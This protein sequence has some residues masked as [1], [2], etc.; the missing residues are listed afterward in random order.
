ML[1]T[2]TSS[3][4]LALFAFCAS[5]L[6]QVNVSY[7][8]RHDFSIALPPGLEAPISQ[9]VWWDFE[10]AWASEELSIDPASW[11]P[12]AQPVGFRP[13]GFD[14]QDVWGRVWNSGRVLVNVNTTPYVG[15]PWPFE[16]QTTVTANS[17]SASATASSS[18]SIEQFIPGGPFTGSIRS[19]GAA[20][21]PTGETN[22][23]Y[24][25]ASSNVALLGQ[26]AD[27]R[28]GTI[29]WSPSLSY[30]PTG[31]TGTGTVR[32]GCPREG[33]RDPV[34]ARVL[35]AD[36]GVLLEELFFD[37][38]FNVERWD[39]PAEVSWSDDTLIYSNIIDGR[40]WITS[41][42]AYVDPSNH[43]TAWLVIT[44]SLITESEDTGIFDELLPLVGSPGTFSIPFPSEIV[45]NYELP[46]LGSFVQFDMGHGLTPEP[47]TLSLL[48]LGG[49]GALLRR[50]K[51]KA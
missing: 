20:S 28:T 22:G 39:L 47:A 2:K 7:D 40:L 14:W 21:A 42:N 31:S 23:A 38:A 11:T 33:P 9:A 17:G 51:S 5:A 30:Q 32:S 34:I 46:N 41:D 8:I 18:V 35:D 36:G 3:V 19:W 12:A 49:L 4:F 45:L 6:G 13:Y 24:A 48:A 16:R 29:L 10:H 1:S 27:W 50:R 25:Y 15:P 26:T 43:G 37:M 44:N